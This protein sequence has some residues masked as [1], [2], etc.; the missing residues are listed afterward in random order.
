[1]ER[2]RTP[3]RSCFQAPPITSSQTPFTYS[4]GT[5]GM[6]MSTL[7]LYF[8]GDPVGSGEMRLVLVY[9]DNTAASNAWFGVCLW[10]TPVP[11][12]ASLLILGLGAVLFRRRR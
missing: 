12:P 8:Y 7:D 1:M 5:N 2:R 3:P 9:T 11:E 4:I 6:G 10:P